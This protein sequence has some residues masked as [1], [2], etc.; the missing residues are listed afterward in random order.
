MWPG[1]VSLIPDRVHTGCRLDVAPG[2]C[3]IASVQSL[4]ELL[5]DTPVLEMGPLPAP[6][7]AITATVHQALQMLVRG[8]RGAVVLIDGQRPVGVFTERDV[9]TRLSEDLLQNSEQRRITPV[10][11]VM[12]FP[13]VTV[14]RQQ[15]LAEA[16]GIMVE[17]RFRHLVLVDRE[18]N[19]RGLM[20]NADIV[21]FVTDLFPEEVVNLPPRLRQRFFTPEGA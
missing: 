21:Q 11:E 1:I 19:L 20:T 4:A 13:P 18:E 7:L 3:R 10:R 12:S 17:R 5:R 14:R 9:V 16:I 8:R 15:S 6:R 2:W